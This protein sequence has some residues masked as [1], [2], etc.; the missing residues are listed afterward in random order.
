MAYTSEYP[1]VYLTAD[2]V[3]LSMHP[4]GGLSVLMVKRGNPPHQGRW[5]FPG[6]FVDEREDVARAA[7]R[8]LG[9]ETGIRSRRLH[10]HQLGV[11]TAPRRDPRHRV[12]SV[13]FVV[14]LPEPAVPT[15]ADDAAHADWLPV[16]EVLG[17]RRV[18]FDHGHILGDALTWVSDAIDRTTLATSFLA[19]EFT[20]TELRQVYEAVWGRKLDPGNFQR[21]VTGAPGFLEDTGERRV[22]GRGRPASLFSAGAATEI[23]P[24]MSRE[25][26]R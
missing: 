2:V 21:K 4:E 26:D 11:Y 23:W 16:D 13:P 7:R 3:A 6:G 14:M 25:R 22:G 15:A 19:T 1:F 9:E 18:A 10:L 17:S 8:E 12:I 20:I 5:A 24:P